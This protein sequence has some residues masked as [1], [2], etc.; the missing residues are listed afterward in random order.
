MAELIAWTDD[1]YDHVFVDCPPMLAAS[2]AALVGRLV[3]ALILVVRPAKNPRR[4][5]LRVAGT[6]ATLRMNVAGVVANFMDDVKSGDYYGYGSQ[7]NYGF[8]AHDEEERAGD[9]EAIEE[10]SH[11][12]VD[13]DRPSDTQLAPRRAA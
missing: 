12:T 13:P 10:K 1:D 7:F 2:D 11:R 9:E 6:L 8:T 3:D 5:V 4:A